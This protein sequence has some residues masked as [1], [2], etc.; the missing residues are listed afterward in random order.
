LIASPLAESDELSAGSP[1]DCQPAW[2][3]YSSAVSWPKHRHARPLTKNHTTGTRKDRR[4][5][6]GP[7][8]AAVTRGFT[9]GSDSAPT[10]TGNGLAD[11]ARNLATAYSGSA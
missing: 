3:G 7:L 9:S 10:R 8:Y 1:M 2:G 4:D 6:P 5:I 11:P